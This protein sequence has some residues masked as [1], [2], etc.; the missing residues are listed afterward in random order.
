M[1][2]RFKELALKSSDRLESDRGF[3]SHSLRQKG[4]FAY[5]EFSFCNNG[6]RRRESFDS[7]CFYTNALNAPLNPA[8]I[9]S[10]EEI[11]AW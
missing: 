11:L 5:A 8:L 1:S 4:N 10:A 9:A 2:E 6:I 7:R 3:E